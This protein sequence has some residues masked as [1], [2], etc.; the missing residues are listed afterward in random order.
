MA[1]LVLGAPL[2]HQNRD[3]NLGSRYSFL[4]IQFLT[5]VTQQTVNNNSY[6]YSPNYSIFPEAIRDTFVSRD[7]GA[8]VVTSLMS[9][10]ACQ[11]LP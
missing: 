9:G 2:W 5:V 6:N 10:H 8:T 7:L 4:S 11:S 1:L 3:P